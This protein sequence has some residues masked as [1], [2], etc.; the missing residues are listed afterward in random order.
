MVLPEF[1]TEGSDCFDVRFQPWGKFSYKGYSFNNKPFDRSVSDGKLVINP[2][3]RVLVPTGLILNIPEGYSVRLHPRSGLALKQGLVLANAEAVIDSD[4]VEELFVILYNQS[5]VQA[6]IFNG[7][8]IA[9]AEL[10]ADLEYTF[11]VTVNRPEQKTS[12]N[13]GL[14][15]TGVSVEPTTKFDVVFTEDEPAPKP[16]RTR[17]KVS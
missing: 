1:A 16:K 8:R 4:Y 15:S 2:G 14:G 10:V 13:G 17:R 9:Q 11:N 7:D 5:N 6:E 3:D 12:R